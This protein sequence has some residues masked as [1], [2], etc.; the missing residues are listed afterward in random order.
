MKIIE[1]AIRIG[2]SVWTGHRHHNIFRTI[3]EET[4]K[5]AFEM[6][7]ELGVA[8]EEQGFVADT[9]EFVDRIEAAK[10]ALESGQIEKLNHPPNLYSEDFY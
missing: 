4:G 5:K 9:G 1:A 7:K 2:D 8:R 10:I 3:F 6:V